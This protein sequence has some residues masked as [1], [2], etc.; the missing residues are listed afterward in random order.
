MILGKFDGK[1]FIKGSWTLN[2]EFVPHNEED[3]E[4]YVDQK[5]DF[6][7]GSLAY[8]ANIKNFNLLN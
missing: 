1:R 7:P 5:L 4:D 3:P 8:Q 2:G 6:V